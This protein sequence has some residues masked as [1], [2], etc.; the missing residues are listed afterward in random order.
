MH[1]QIMS[2]INI[3]TTNNINRI[4]KIDI[5]FDSRSPVCE[6]RHIEIYRLNQCFL[7][8]TL[9]DPGRIT[10]KSINII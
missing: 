7:H 3:L 6:T 2:F 9:L 8:T 5:P 10:L 4:L 1:M